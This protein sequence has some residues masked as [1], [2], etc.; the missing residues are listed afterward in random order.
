MR[1]FETL[2]NW[3]VFTEYGLGIVILTKGIIQCMLSGS[4]FSIVVGNKSV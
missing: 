3:L 4:M 1:L 2:L